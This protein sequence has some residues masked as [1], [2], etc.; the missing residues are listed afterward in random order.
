MGSLHEEGAAVGAPYVPVFSAYSRPSEADEANH[1]IA[2]SLQLLAGM[3]AAEAR[4]LRDEAALAALRRMRH[5]I[6]AV[7]RIH[8]QLSR[9]GGP[10][11]V[12]LGQYV[13]D[14]ARQLEVACE[15]GRQ[16]DVVADGLPA[17]AEEARAVGVI[18]SEVV[19][20]ACKYAYPAGSAGIIRVALVASGPEDH[21]LTVE[22]RGR[23]RSG[24]T[25]GGGVG[26]RVIELTAQSIGASV[27]WEDAKPGTRFK[28]MIP[29]R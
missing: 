2:N 9:S 25:F 11:V 8:G 21:V 28:L 14:L 12:D 29:A 13:R 18:L 1:R 19:A 23:G 27:V 15:D 16:V 26:T 17:S 22:D 20:N 6:D 24:V 4:G 5:R 10:A 7:A 3:M